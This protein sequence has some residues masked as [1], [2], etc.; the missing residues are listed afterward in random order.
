MTTPARC[1]CGAPQ[2]LHV[3]PG[4]ACPRHTEDQRVYARTKPAGDGFY[5]WIRWAPGRLVLLDA[6]DTVVLD[7]AH[8]RVRSLCGLVAQD[9]AR[10]AAARQAPAEPAPESAGE[11]PVGAPQE[12]LW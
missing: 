8:E 6:D 12:A 1:G 9:R 3:L 2:E 10:V 5:G 11:R 4:R 7:V